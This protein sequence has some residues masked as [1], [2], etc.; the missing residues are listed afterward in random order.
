MTNELNKLL[1]EKDDLA[2][3]VSERDALT[4]K[5]EERKREKRSAAVMQALALINAYGLTR[6]ELF[7]SSGGGSKKAVKA[8]KDREP[9]FRNPQTGQTWAGIGKPPNWYTAAQD[10]AALMIQKSSG[11]SAAGKSA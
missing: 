4:A 9:K 3:L 7:Q 10:K 2:K 11:V 8:K 6:Q 1:D 5:I